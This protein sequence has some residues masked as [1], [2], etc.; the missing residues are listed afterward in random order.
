MP[1]T[2]LPLLARPGQP[3]V[4]FD[5]L[6]A[7]LRE[8]VGFRL[9]TLLF[10]DGDEVARIYS[11]QPEAYPV[12]GRKTMGPTP[13]GAHVIKGRKPWLGRG[14]A[15]IEWAFYDHELIASLGCGDCINLPV[16]YDGETVGT[17]NLLD[18]EGRYDETHLAA[19]L[20]FAPLAVPGFLAAR[21]K[22]NAA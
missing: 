16:V 3:D 5:A 15:D 8:V 7:R 20:P 18:A 4:L 17:F 1:D 6:S 19:V 2:L 13:W 10:V 12:S 9:F 11:N 21:F 14:R 22:A